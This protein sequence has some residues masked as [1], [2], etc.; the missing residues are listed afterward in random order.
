M[1]SWPRLLELGPG[2][3]NP[4]LSVFLVGPEEGR[5]QR[6]KMGWRTSKERRLRWEWT[7]VG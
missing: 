7:G 2:E 4:G 5:K 3:S 1:L 6:Q